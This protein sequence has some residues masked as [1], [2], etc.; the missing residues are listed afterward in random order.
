M[1]AATI[2]LAG[3]MSAE[4]AAT[5][6]PSPT[7]PYDWTT[8][9]GDNQRT[10]WNKNE[11]TLT[12]DNVRNLK[13][14]WK[15]DTSNQVRALH[16]LMPVLVLSRLSTPAGVR[17]VGIVTGIS[18]NIYAFD[19]ET[20]KILWQKHWDYAPPAAGRGAAAPP[21]GAQGAPA[22]RGAPQN[23]ASLGFLRPGGSGDVPV[24]GPPDGQGR[25]PVFRDGRRHHAYAERRH[26][27]RSRA[28]VHVPRGKGWALNLVNDTIFMANTYANA[29]VVAVELDDPQHKVMTFNANSG[30]AWGRRGA[31]S[32]RQGPCSR[33]LV[34]ASTTLRL[35]SMPTASS[36]SRSWTAS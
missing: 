35:G 16:A 6:V 23:P 11:R 12:K 34:T 19:V 36:R 15:I 24:I 31:V 2:I 1:W 27:R 7:A 33:P 10:G 14:L 21:A 22:G 18:D 4:R 29:S 17:Q 30:G 20:G 13:L 5:Q 28:V 26:G 8:D 32:T 9:G 3:L 25:R